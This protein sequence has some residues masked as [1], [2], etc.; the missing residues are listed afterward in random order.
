MAQNNHI[1]F[2]V[3]A[4]KNIK[5]LEQYKTKLKLKPEDI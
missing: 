5:N 1:E 2:V 3:F 4:L